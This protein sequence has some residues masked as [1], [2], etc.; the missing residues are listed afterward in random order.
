MRFSTPILGYEEWEFY[1]DSD[2]TL[3][4]RLHIKEISENVLVV[5]KLG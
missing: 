1:C 4:D 3:G 2:V 5:T